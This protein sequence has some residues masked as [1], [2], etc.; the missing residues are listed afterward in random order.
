MAEFKIFK[1]L[2]ALPA[3]LE[4]NA[5]Y[6][7]RI[8]VGFDLYATTNTEPIVARK[9]NSDGSGGGS[10]S[11]GTD[12]Q[13]QLADGS[14]GF[15]ASKI[16]EISN[17]ISINDL[18]TAQ[19]VG[20]LGAL[21]N[22]FA[23]EDAA[24]NGGFITNDLN[25]TIP[26]NTQ[27]TTLFT[28]LGGLS[29]AGGKLKES[30]T[31]YW[32]INNTGTNDIGFSVRG[33]GHR[34]GL[35]DSSYTGINISGRFHSIDSHGD[36]VEF[37]SNS[38]SVSFLTGLLNFGLSVRLVK[39][40]TNGQP[41]KPVVVDYEGN[42]YKVIEVGNQLWITEN[43]RTKRYANGAEILTIA[44]STTWRTTT[45]RGI[46]A[47]LNDWSNVLH[48]SL[49]GDFL[50]SDSN[51]NLFKIAGILEKLKSLTNVGTLPIVNIGNI[52]SGNSTQ[53]INV[54]ES[55][56]TLMTLSSVNLTII[57]S[58]IFGGEF[59]K[60]SIIVLSNNHSTETREVS[61]SNGNDLWWANANPLIYLEPRKKYLISIMTTETL[62]LEI[63]YAEFDI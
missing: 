35:P 41:F 26:T 59:S 55:K 14:G 7:V 38:D 44:N 8:G 9:V 18:L 13:V 47:Y 40:H 37:L 23:L 53:I 24:L 48:S 62:S 25:W 17:Q 52:L 16:K 12:G 54:Q 29:V 42:T 56:K 50:I 49:S 1:V 34:V 60:Q 21:Y 32:D 27:W 20:K 4:S 3:I 46:C 5:L 58:G 28:E 31:D 57:F 2:D 61:W 43:L 19:D 11:Q 30:G 39:E 33:C 51:N 36:G 63:N 6:L 10:A 15:K 45:Y 22:Y